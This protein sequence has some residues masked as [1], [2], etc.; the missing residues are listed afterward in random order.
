M[1]VVLIGFLGYNVYQI[2][3][4]KPIEVPD[5]IAS[6][7][8]PVPPPPPGISVDAK[9]DYNNLVARN[10]F[11]YWS[12]AK[13][14]GSGELRAED[15]GVELLSIRDLGDGKLRAQLR[16]R[17]AKKWYDQGESFEVFR[18]EEINQ[19]E[20]AVVVYS[21]EHAKSVTIRRN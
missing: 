13:L 21:V 10:P 11:S 12:D 17:S 8:T 18:L 4:P 15:I 7:E 6:K 1:L 5:F 2:F 3:E 14:S 20:D 16:T 19:A 9:G